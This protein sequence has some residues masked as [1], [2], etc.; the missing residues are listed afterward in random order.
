[1]NHKKYMALLVVGVS[2]TAASLLL[3]ACGGGEPAATSAPSQTTTAPTEPTQTTLP[4]VPEAAASLPS[5]SEPKTWTETE[6]TT[7]ET[8]YVKLESDFL[9]VRTG[10]GTTYKQVAAL[11]NGMQVT[12]VAKTADEW[13][14]LDS[15]YFVSGEFLTKD[16]PA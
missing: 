2:L 7:P 12:V 4:P 10:P 3:T 5:N 9:R 15:G 8:R 14:K 11:T 16:K 13:Y 6:F 1:M